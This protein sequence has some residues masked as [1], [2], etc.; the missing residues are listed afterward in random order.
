[1]YERFPSIQTIAEES[2][3]WPGVTRPTYAAGLGFGF[4]WDMGWMHDT[5][6][7]LARPPEQRAGAQHE[8]TFRSNYAA[9]ENF[10][11]AFSHDE[12]VHGK[13]SLLNKMPG[14]DW[15]Q[16]ASL[17]LLYG[18]QW[19]TPGKKSLFMGSEFA[20][21]REWNHDGELDWTLAAD[22]RHAGV[23]RWIGDLNRLYRAT[24]ALHEGDVGPDGLHWLQG[25]DNDR[26]VLA[27]ARCG[28]DQRAVA[29]VVANFANQVWRNH[30]V[31][32][33][34]A[35]C[36]TE[37]LNSDAVVY[38]GSGQGNFGTVEAA[39]LGYH[40]YPPAARS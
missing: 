4:K 30:R 15:G 21:E 5:L 8:L 6:G 35:G 19:T 14:D 26:A 7:H 10:V 27:Y 12:V 29:I 18:Y 23:A 9:T 24:P 22:Q 25:N 33:P 32:V 3:A 28:S 20:S 16:R 36:W 11:L 1:V 39:P 40:G 34:V 38:G 2:T 17:R 31:G 13:G 37:A